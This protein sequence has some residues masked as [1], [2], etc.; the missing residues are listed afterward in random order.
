MFKKMEKKD[1]SKIYKTTLKA[2]NWNRKFKKLFF[3]KVIAENS[4]NKKNINT[5][6]ILNPEEPGNSIKFIFGKKTNRTVQ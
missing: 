4:I 6:S 5:S 1:R 3:N 2:L